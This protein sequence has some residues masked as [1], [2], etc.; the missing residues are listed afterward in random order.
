MRQRRHLFIALAS[1]AGVCAF[2]SFGCAENV[3][4]PYTG[5]AV[6]IEVAF[7]EHEAQMKKAQAE[8]AL[9]TKETEEKQKLLLEQARIETE[10]IKR[11]AVKE[12]SKVDT[13]ARNTI[14]DIEAQAKDELDRVAT[15]AMTAATSLRLE[16]E[17]YVSELKSNLDANKAIL[18]AFEA[19]ERARAQQW[20][21]FIQAAEPLT[22]AGA[23]AANGLVPGLGVG[24]LGGLALIV[25]H[26]NGRAAK[27]R[28]D[29]AW[30]ESAAEAEKKQA[31][32]DK[33]WDEAT[34]R[35]EVKAQQELLLAQNKQLQELVAKL[36]IERA[37]TAAS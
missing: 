28:E 1:L 20:L 13:N 25:Q 29:T 6:P 3:T 26:L 16:N 5:K 14:G 2:L 37:P 10:R 34:A 33:A 21:G 22:T 7:A 15:E 23:T 32:A 31:A 4:S 19:Q 17:K 9:K 24:L 27:K 8:A 11:T 36:S 35:A 30:A 18:D 12:A